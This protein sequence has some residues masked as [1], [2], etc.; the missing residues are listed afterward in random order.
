MKKYQFVFNIL[1]V[2]VISLFAVYADS[3]MKY[4][5]FKETISGII[6]YIVMA[7]FMISLYAQLLSQDKR[8]TQFTKMWI[9]WMIWLFAAFYLL[10][11][12]G[13]GLSNY[14]IVTLAPMSFMLF[15]VGALNSYNI[16]KISL[17]GFYIVFAL[18]YYQTI[19]M[20]DVILLTNVFGEEGSQSNIVYWCLCPLP[21]L[22]LVKNK[23]LQILAIM[24]M[25][26]ITILTGKR[27]AT[28]IMLTVVFFY[29][30]N[31]MKRRNKFGYAFAI[32]IGLVAGYFIVYN[33]LADAFGGLVERMEVMGAEGDSSM[34]RV[35]IYSDCLRVM[36]G[37]DVFD[38]IFGRGYESVRALSGH[39][40]AHNDALQMLFE[41]GLIG[42]C[43]YIYMLVYS[44]KR[45]R[46]LNKIESPF[47]VGYMASVVIFIVLGL[48]SNLVVF[49]SY[50]AYIC[51]FWGMVEARL[52]QQGVLYQ[53]HANF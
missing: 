45:A 33:Y 5:E 34:S 22:L 23:W 46:L 37:N 43:F 13:E 49:Y 39:T 40:N 38:W 50:F 4:L 47:Y 18:A 19:V 51:A 27:S 15:Y 52:R 7:V 44:I 9:I 41:Y 31:N 2:I 28:I 25:I 42:L 48:V 24:L 6:N 1:I 26:F 30:T 32:L 11:L 21:F 29:L 16:E 12:K 14:F 53:R 3:M 17:V 20:M 36:N 10:G 35:D 8:Q